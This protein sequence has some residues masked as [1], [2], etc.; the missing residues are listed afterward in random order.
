MGGDEDFRG[1]AK[2]APTECLRLKVGCGKA[3][4][5]WLKVGCGKAADLWL[6]VGCGKAA[7]LRLAYCH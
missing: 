7:D 6:K 3:A 5:L 2:G 1:G 4:D